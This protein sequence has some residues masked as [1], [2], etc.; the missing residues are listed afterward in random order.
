MWLRS[1]RCRYC[2]YAVVIAASA[3]YTA[4]LS[5][6]S[7]HNYTQPA[8][9]YCFALH[10]TTGNIHTETGCCTQIFNISRLLY[11]PRSFLR[12]KTV[13]EQIHQ[14]SVICCFFSLIHFVASS[15]CFNYNFR[16]YVFSNIHNLIQY[17]CDFVIAYEVFISLNEIDLIKTF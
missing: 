13:Y 15:F 8:Y 6:G 10:N 17:T 16:F 5:F 14:L 1:Q 9:N 12:D 4:R 2:T 3:A 7:K 11:A